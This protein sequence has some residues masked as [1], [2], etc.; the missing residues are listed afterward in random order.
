MIQLARIASV[1]AKHRKPSALRIEDLNAMIA[2]VR[3]VNVALCVVCHSKRMVKL[4]WAISL[5]SNLLEPAK[6][7]AKDL[8]AVISP[9]GHKEPSLFIRG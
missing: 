7:R 8:N 6:I 3:N 5:M 2:A 1:L 9:I 4:A